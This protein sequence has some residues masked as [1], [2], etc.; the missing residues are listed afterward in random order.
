MKLTSDLIKFVEKVVKIGGSVNIDEII[1]DAEAGAVRG[2][3]EER[4]VVL[5]QDEGVP[6]FPVS[7]IGLKRPGALLD[8]LEI[9]KAQKDFSV[10]AEI[11]TLDDIE[12]VKALHMQSADGKTKVGFRCSNPETIKAPKQINDTIIYRV[13]L[14][15]EA[16]DVLQKGHGAMGT[17]TVSVVGGDGGVAFELQ[18]ISEDTMRHV[19]AE[20]AI[21]LGE[22]TGSFTHKYPIKTL[23]ALFKQNPDG[24]FEIGVKGILR[25]EVNGL[26]L[27]VLPQV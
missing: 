24:E 10:D 12:Y 6:E 17:E 4:S 13:Q 16:V 8:R 18:D 5:F 15:A 2:I 21:Q 23:L 25:I 22:A 19:F 11:V 20:D 1:I 7:S 26:N 9:V 14:N 27:Y 3:D